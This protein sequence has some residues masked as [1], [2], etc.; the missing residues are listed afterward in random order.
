MRKQL[1]FAGVALALACG[2]FSYASPV[3]GQTSRI[4]HSFVGTHSASPQLGREFWIPVMM[5]GDVQTGKVI[6]LSI[7]SAKPTTAYIQYFGNATVPLKVNPYKKTTYSIP[8]TSEINSSSIIEN[9]GIRVWS[10]D[11]D[12]SCTLLSF[13]SGSSEGFYVNPVIGWGREYGVVAYPAMSD[14]LRHDRPSE[15]A[16]VA[17]QDNTIVTITPSCDIRR[18]VT[19]HASSTVIAHAKGVV[20]SDT[21]RRG[22][23]VQYENVLATDCTNYDVT[24]TIIRAN[25]PIGL[26]AG[27]VDAEQ[28]CT[29][30]IGDY[31]AEMLPPTQSWGKTYYASGTNQLSTIV[32][33][34]KANQIIRK[35]DS[36]SHTLTTVCTLARPFDHFTIP[37]NNRAT[38]YESDTAFLA[39][40]YLISSANPASV[41]LK[42]VEQYQSRTIFQVDSSISNS[43]FSNFANIVVNANAIGSTTLDG[44]QL[45]G[46][47]RAGIDG[48]YYVYTGSVKPGVHLL[49]SDSGADVYLGGYTTN[50]FYARTGALGT[51]VYNSPDQTP[52]IAVPQDQCYGTRM[53]LS[54]TGI[55]QTGILYIALDTQFNFDY[56]IDSTW[57]EGTERGTTYYDIHVHDSTKPAQLRISIYD[58]A[59]NKTAI[60]SEYIPQAALIAPLIQDF[61]SVNVKAKSPAFLYDTLINQ[62]DVSFPIR[63]FQFGTG[64]TSVFTIDSLS[65][66]PLAPQER[67]A[68]KIGFWPKTTIATWATL[69]F[70]D[71]CIQQEVLLRGA[72]AAADFS[73]T[74]A[75]FG[76]VHV[77]SR[78]NDSVY[79]INASALIPVTVANIAMDS[80]VFT[81]LPNALP[82]VVPPLG[83]KKVYIA[84]T[85]SDCAPVASRIHVTSIEGDVRSAT[86]KG[87]GD[88]ADV[89]SQQLG[90][91]QPPLNITSTGSLRVALPSNIQLPATLELSDIL[92]K[93]ILRF[94][95]SSTSQE[96]DT[97]SLQSGVFFYRLTNG[98]ES[99]SGKIVITAK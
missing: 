1:F 30:G 81:L 8:V 4:S 28:T 61:G 3:V 80:S 76:A 88:C 65:L 89:R 82:I 84:F 71:E 38:R 27:C 43:V 24:G 52:P 90:G 70:G 60:F 54:D 86:L 34:T 50:E 21:L 83:R 68:I 79:V 18:E 29:A 87:V 55:A 51:S 7:T 66:T 15:F 49:Y 48:K 75:D 63:T 2:I 64:D 47:A 53:M 26:T 10:N 78:R 92:G 41:V 25:H 31:V 12:L 69:L 23:T 22:Q 85:P 58:Y 42:P 17:N 96:I 5:I 56:R 74:D 9:K 6:T 95:L 93:S 45:K 94:S 46:F 57:I 73:V 72:G 35:Y 14:S 40:Q 59:G 19:P 37:N 16:I 13:I 91:T 20:F 97:R 32:I 98:K 67:R 36:I 44:L 11:A 33:G 39:V 77:Q 62:G 99:A